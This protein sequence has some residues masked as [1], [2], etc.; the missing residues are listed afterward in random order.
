MLSAE[1]AGE[2]RYE[3][4][5]ND[6]RGIYIRMDRQAPGNNQHA[7]RP[8]PP[9]APRER[10]LDGRFNVLFNSFSVYQDDGRM[11]MKGCVQWNPVYG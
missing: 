11:I 5:K 1:P 4:L 7:N 2:H 10:Q 8:L 6:D 3:N 9:S